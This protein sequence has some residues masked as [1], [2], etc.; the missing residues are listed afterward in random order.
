MTDNPKDCA[1]DGSGDPESHNIIQRTVVGFKSGELRVYTASKGSDREKRMY[2]WVADSGTVFRLK[3][4]VNHDTI[5]VQQVEG[6]HHNEPERVKQAQALA[7]V[8]NFFGVTSLADL[9]GRIIRMSTDINPPLDEQ[10]QEQLCLK[11]GSLT[12]PRKEC[13][14][15]GYDDRE[16]YYHQEQC[17]QED[18]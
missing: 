4:G 10:E 11:C 9:Y 18:A 3:D 17:R 16:W 14:V 13:T 15:C 6:D 5:V 2:E 12:D 1:A 8:M 7:E